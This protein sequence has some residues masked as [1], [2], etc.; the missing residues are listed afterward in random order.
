MLAAAA[1][2][3]QIAY[4]L[5]SGRALDAVTA[6]VVV[7][8]AAAALAHAAATRSPA[9]AAGFLAATA[10]LGL[11]AEVAGTATGVPFG[12]YSYATDRLGPHLAGVPLV[13]PL[14]WTGGFYPLW[15]AVEVVARRLGRGRGPQVALAAAT[16][17]GWDLYLDPQ[18][19]AAG[20]WT[21]CS[22]HPGL[23]GLEV[24]PYTNYLGWLAVAAAMALA[25]SL[26]PGAVPP[27]RAMAVPLALF[28]WTWLGS[29]LAHLVFLD[30][31]GLRGSAWYGLAGMGATGVALLAALARP[32]RA[33]QVTVAQRRGA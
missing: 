18:M 6:A 10:G 24:I 32:A 5:V 23:P 14:A 1:V 31:G 4:P 17:V 16:A 33:P 12:C 15:C 29:A 27:A 28:L 26:L 21:W 30:L 9:W 20:Y 3:A 8:L 13:V 11:L 7:L 25:V 22:P 2:G 19:V